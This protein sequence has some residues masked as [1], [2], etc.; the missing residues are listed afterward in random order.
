MA[1]SL[2]FELGLSA[3]S[4]LLGRR[5]GYFSAVVLRHELKSRASS[6]GDDEKAVSTVKKA[7][8]FPCQLRAFPAA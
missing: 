6:S 3:L 1:K 2:N 4:A 7:V 5:I 8:S